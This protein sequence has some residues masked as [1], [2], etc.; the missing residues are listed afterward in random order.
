[1]VAKNP[2]SG[3]AH[4]YR[5]RYHR[6]LA[7]PADEKD[8][9]RALE[10]AP[11]DRE[12]LLAAALDGEQRRDAAAVR[13]YL[14]K[15]HRLDPKD[16][17]FALG[18]ARTE[19]RDGHLDRAE[20]ILRGAFEAR[21]AVGMA[22]ELAD[23]LILEGKI[24]GSDGAEELIGKLRRAGLGD[25]LVRFL[26]AEILYQGKK[27]KE[28]IDALETARAVVTSAPELTL[29]I[30]L[31]LADCHGRLGDDEKRLE[32][33]RRAAEGRQGE[34]VARMELV[35]VLARSGQLDRAITTLSP[36]AV[37]GTN[38]QWRLD[39]V[40]LLLEKTMRQPPERRDWTEV[41]RQLAEAEKARGGAAEPPVLLRLAVL[42]ARDR[43]EDARALLTRSLEKEPRN[44]GYRLAMARLTQRQGQP[45]QALRIIEQA[46]KDLGPGPQI[47]LARLDYWGQAGGDA[48]RAAV[49]KLAAARGQI[50]AADRPA[51]LDRLGAAAIRLGRPD[52]AR[53]YGREQASLQPEDL[54]IRL[55]LFDLAL[56]A[57]DRD[58]PTRLVD[59]IRKIEGE[60]GS[61][62]RFARAALLIDQA[63]RG[64][65]E[66][67]EEARRLADEIT[68]TQARLV[69]GA[70]PPRRDRRA[71]RLDRPGHR[72]LPG[73]ARARQRAALV[74]PP[75]GG[76]ARPAGPARRG[77]SRD[78]GAPGAGR[79][80]G[81]GHAG[82]GP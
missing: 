65:A 53:Q 74:R 28:A 12:V 57:G 25:T 7:P 52:L 19:M 6:E 41:E 11:D 39:L 9:A 55:R 33:L 15:G 58:E 82:A 37:A 47:D 76:A 42:A 30:N 50:P 16:P 40:R 13:T 29:R 14:E 8:I 54:A 18:L 68:E 61:N 3:R 22:F 35:R 43:L 23:V 36:L 63:R 67:L 59:E 81:R 51:F 32:V 44:L 26:E 62:W 75:A 38:P 24:E 78:A 73:G 2:R 79:G 48:A 31:M 80:A 56:S 66:A 49:A 34:D 69:G 45:D 71:G 5:W 72:V 70:R 20:A 46:E 10:L 64:S 4:A 1:M 27:W 21:P 60:A 77:R 17:T